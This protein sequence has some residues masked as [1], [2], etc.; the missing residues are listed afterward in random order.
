MLRTAFTALSVS[1][2]TLI[3]SHMFIVKAKDAGNGNG[4]YAK[5]M[6]SDIVTMPLAPE[7]E[8]VKGWLAEPLT[9]A[10]TRKA[11]AKEMRTRMEML[12]LKV[13][14]DFVNALQREEDPKYRY[15]NGRLFCYLD[16]HA[17]FAY[18]LR[19]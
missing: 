4:D 8:Q 2:A 13:Q 15:V 12:I 3:R 5:R 19:W 11:S 18:A 10:S 14:Q 16:M 1:G 7:S 6:E 9:D 17:Y